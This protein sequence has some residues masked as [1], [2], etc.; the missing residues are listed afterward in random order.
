MPAGSEARAGL[1]WPAIVVVALLVVLVGAVTGWAQATP[2]ATSTAEADDTVTLSSLTGSV[3]VDP[4]PGWQVT[5]RSEEQ[6]RLTHRGDTVSVTALAVGTPPGSLSTMFQRRAR[7]L[8]LGDIA[9]T[10][11]QSRRTR[12]GY[13]GLD[14][15]AVGH[16]MIGRLTVLRRGDRAV[17]VLVLAAPSRLAGYEPQLDR[18]Y[19]SIS[20]AAA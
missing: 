19:D 2:A 3:T 14:G 18:L 13:R 12:H 20:G 4:I 16:G 7:R 15:T 9:A 5:D 17:S 6:L 1:R 10:Q 11:Q 8:T